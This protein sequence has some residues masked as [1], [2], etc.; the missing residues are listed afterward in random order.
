MNYFYKD[1]DRL[2]RIVRNVT[3]QIWK[4]ETNIIK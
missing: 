2:I 1:K 3:Y 4:G